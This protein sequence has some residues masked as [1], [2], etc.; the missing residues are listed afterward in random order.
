MGI[1]HRK[2]KQALN[3]FAGIDRSIHGF[4][5]V[6]LLVVLTI[7]AALVTMAFPIVYEFR[8]KSRSSRAAIEIR[9]LEKDIISFAT[10]KGRYPLTAEVAAASSTTNPI[11]VP[12][13]NLLD[14]WGNN[15]EYKS[16]NTRTYYGAPINTDFDLWSY[17]PKKGAADNS[18]VDPDSLDDIVRAKDGSFNELAEKYAIL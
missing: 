11:L 8:D 10:E 12:L 18:I 2:P 13:K 4:T 17:G 3:R 15:Y 14:P 6:E 16:A 5:L 7:V 9:G 1:T